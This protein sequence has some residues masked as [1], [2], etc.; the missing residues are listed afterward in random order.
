ME[1]ILKIL[2]KTLFIK[3]GRKL[4][5]EEDGIGGAINSAKKIVALYEG[6]YPG[7]FTKWLITQHEFEQESEDCWYK[8]G[9]GFGEDNEYTFD[10]LLRWWQDNVEGK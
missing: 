1:K 10:D 9:G 6:W 5:D 2:Q 7:E 8:L 4:F 3:R